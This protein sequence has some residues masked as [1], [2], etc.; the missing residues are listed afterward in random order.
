VSRQVTHR[1]TQMMMLNL[2]EQKL[3][4]SRDCWKKRPQNAANFFCTYAIYKSTYCC[5]EPSPQQ[6]NEIQHL[7]RRLPYLRSATKTRIPLR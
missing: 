5:L 2:L 1:K 6:N 3:M 7:I 4:L